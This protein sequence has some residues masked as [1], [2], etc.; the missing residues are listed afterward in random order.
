LFET[1]MRDRAPGID[2]L[3]ILGDLFEAWVGDDDRCEANERIEASIKSLVDAGT[4]VF[5]MHGNRDFLIAQAFSE[6]TGA[7][8]LTDPSVINLYGQATLLMHGDSLCTDD[9]KHQEYRATAYTEQGK[10]QLLAHPLDARLAMASAARKKSQ[11]NKELT[12]AAIMDV[13]LD[14]VSDAMREHQVSHLIHGHT[15]RHAHHEF[16]LDGNTAHRY[17]L[18]E[19]VT[20]GATLVCSESGCVEEVIE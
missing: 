18:R 19:W 12:P 6:R 13:N 17:V 16:D 20:E 14:A 7:S 9:L 1:F 15:H 5:F 2:A 8:L 11:A 3:Y 10:A 4:A